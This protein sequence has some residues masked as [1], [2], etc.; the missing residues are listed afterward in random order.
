MVN[1]Q[2]GTYRKYKAV[3]K[4][5]L[6]FAYRTSRPDQLIQLSHR[7]TARQLLALDKMINH[8]SVL[9]SAISI[10]ESTGQQEHGPSTTHVK[11]TE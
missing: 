2:K 9:D 7:F 6:C 5:L 10:S 11:D 1:L 4:R 8:T 3:W